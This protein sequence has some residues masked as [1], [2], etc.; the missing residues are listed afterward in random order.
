MTKI[1]KIS[2]KREIINLIL[3]QKRFLAENLGNQ[4]T[5]PIIF[6]TFASFRIL[7]RPNTKQMNLRI[8][9]T[10]LLF[11]PAFAMMAQNE[12]PPYKANAIIIP[13]SLDYIDSI[14]SA[15]PDSIRILEEERFDDLNSGKAIVEESEVIEMFDT[16]SRIK[17]FND[18]FILTDTTKLNIYGYAKD[19]V[20]E[21]ADSI[22][23]QRIDALARETTIPLTYNAHVKSFIELYAMRKRGLTSKMLGLSYVYFPMFEEML[24]KYNMPLEIKYLA[25][26][27][28]ALNPVAGSRA[29]AKGLWQFMYNTGK[30]YNLKVTSMVD[31]R[32]DP[33]KSTEAACQHLQDLYNAY[34]DWFLALAAYNAGAG[35]VNKAIRRAG[36]VK[37]YWAIWPFL[38]KETRGYVPAFIAVNYVINYSSEHNIYPTNPGMIMLGTDTVTVHDYLAFDQINE[39][40]GVPMEDLEF[41]NPQYTKGIIPASQNA[42]CLLRLPSKFALDF[43]NKEKDIYSFKSKAGIDREKIAEEVKKVSN[44]SVHV[45]KS[46]ENLGAIAR[47]YHVSVKQLK[48]WN[49]KKSDMIHPGQKLLVYSSGAPMAQAGDHAPVERST[50]QKIHTVKS[51]ENLGL[52]AKK[53]KCSITNLCKWN[54]IKNNT[55]YPGQKLKVF[56]PSQ[57]SESCSSNKK[58]GFVTYTVKSGDSLS[59]IAEKFDGVTV[60]Q[61]QKLNKMTSKSIIKPGQKLKIQKI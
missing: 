57:S 14:D 17:Y 26:V 28:S 51:G 36:G 56:P 43:V 24:D 55:I 53:Y 13:D 52:I 23:M 4:I 27:E 10:A 1:Y 35:N 37:D 20:P 34:G 32:F 11:T 16:L 5:R 48:Q 6:V 49:N 50:V 9:L 12:I 41:F 61:I 22:Y 58:D 19:Y 30:V 39:M 42:T 45:V 46:G 25:M 38:P 59:K 40:L 60:S 8:I 3:N 54:D 47:K 33:V 29:G 7:S 44:R 15:L 18:Y 21:F 31:D 2:R